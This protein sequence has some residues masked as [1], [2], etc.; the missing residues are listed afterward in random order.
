MENAAS[1][2]SSWFISRGICESLLLNKV[3]ATAGMPFKMGIY[4]AWEFFQMHYKDTHLQYAKTHDIRVLTDPELILCYVTNLLDK[5]S[6]TALSERFLCTISTVNTDGLIMSSMLIFLCLC[7]F[8]VSWLDDDYIGYIDGR[9]SGFLLGALPSEDEKRDAL[10]VYKQV[11]IHMFA[12]LDYNI[13]I[14]A[15]TCTF[16]MDMNSY[17]S[18]SDFP[19][20]PPL[21]NAEGDDFCDNVNACKKQKVIGVKVGV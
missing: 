15:K 4:R 8:A 5:C 20:Q 11:K 14:D 3:Y 12:L 9:L 17:R 7:D 16:S 1:S 6:R 19:A 18:F 10:F 2:I 21:S 13:Y